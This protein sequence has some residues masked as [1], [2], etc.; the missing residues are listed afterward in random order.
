M[1]DAMM[2]VLMPRNMIK[3]WNHKYCRHGAVSTRQWRNMAG[4]IYTND[5]KS[6][7]NKTIVRFSEV[8]NIGQQRRNMVNLNIA[9]HN[10]CQYLRSIVP[11]YSDTKVNQFDRTH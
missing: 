6:N 4:N 9:A 1:R 3:N 10:D 8:A 5:R 2:F 7:E 11:T